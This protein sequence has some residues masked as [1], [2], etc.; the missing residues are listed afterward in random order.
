MLKNYKNILIV[1]FRIF[2]LSYQIFFIPLQLK[3]IQL[4]N[5]GSEKITLHGMCV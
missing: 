5:Y 2:V 1:F 4:K 3:P